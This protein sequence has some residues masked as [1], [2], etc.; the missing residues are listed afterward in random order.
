MQSPGN[1]FFPKTGITVHW[2]SIN[3]GSFDPEFIS[4][5]G[6]RKTYRIFKSSSPDKCQIPPRSNH[7]IVFN[8][9]WAVFEENTPSFTSK[10]Y[11]SWNQRKKMSPHMCLQTCFSDFSF[12][13]NFPNQGGKCRFETPST[14]APSQHLF[15]T[16]EPSSTI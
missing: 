8:W 3:I 9:Y 11:D 7:I 14:S 6:S 15:S 2:Y 12:Q 16:S 1:Q 5:L 10:I 4:L 13:A